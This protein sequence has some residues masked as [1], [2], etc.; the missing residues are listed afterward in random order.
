LAAWTGLYLIDVSI[1]IATTEAGKNYKLDVIK[2]ITTPVVV[3]SQ[4]FDT[5][6]T[7][8]TT[9]TL[10][11]LV[12]LTAAD[13]VYVELSSNCAGIVTVGVSTLT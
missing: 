13:K 9:L 1:L 6:A 12:T 4:Q 10:A 7:G 2:S 5:V 8:Q 3:A 11:S